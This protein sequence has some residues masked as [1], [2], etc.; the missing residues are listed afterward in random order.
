M[1][2]LGHC[3]LTGSESA[4]VRRRCTIVVKVVWRL[5]QPWHISGSSIVRSSQPAHDQMSGQV[6]GNKTGAV[7][8]EAEVRPNAKLARRLMST[9]CKVRPKHYASKWDCCI[10]TT[11]IAFQS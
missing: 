7:A 1:K 8:T 3:V 11:P 9:D 6:L 10:W 2:F 5:L 4:Y